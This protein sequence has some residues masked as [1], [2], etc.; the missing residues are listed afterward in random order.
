MANILS[1][2]SVAIISPLQSI[3]LELVN[4]L[5]SLV[6]AIVVLIL[7]CFVAVI[8]GH[9]LRV[10]LE[11]LKVDDY[12]RKAKLTKAV[13]HTHLPAVLGE[14][15]KW[16]IIILFLGQAVSLVNLGV[17]SDL[18]TRLVGWLPQVLVAVIILLGGLA[19]AHYIEMKLQEYSKLKGIR[20]SAKLLKWVVMIASALIALDYIGVNVSLANNLIMIVVGAVALGVALALGIGL[21]LSLKKESQDVINSLKKNF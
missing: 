8:L 5:P 11:K 1:D 10:V 3:W 14:L 19:I 17:L 18:L 7:G 6:A 12:V 20:T 2:T 16:W 15:F 13:G 9:T 4:R 21:G